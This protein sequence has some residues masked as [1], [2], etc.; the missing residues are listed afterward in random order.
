M[1]NC[2]YFYVF[3]GGGIACGLFSTGGCLKSQQKYIIS[4]SSQQQVKVRVGFQLHS[5]ILLSR[6]RRNFVYTQMTD[7][8]KPHLKFR[9][10]FSNDNFGFILKHVTN[11]HILDVISENKRKLSF[12]WLKFMQQFY[13]YNKS[14]IESIYLSGAGPWFL[15]IC[16]NNSYKR[17]V[18]SYPRRGRSWSS[19]NMNGPNKWHT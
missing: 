16:S 19:R 4:G 15:S 3:N 2:S 13:T 8:S 12:H 10:Q 9:T 18:K 5:H 1:L 6:R 14:Q 7:E 11:E 17:F